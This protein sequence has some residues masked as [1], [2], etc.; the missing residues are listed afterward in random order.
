MKRPPLATGKMGTHRLGG[1]WHYPVNPWIYFLFFLGVNAFL[2]YATDSLELKFW[3]GLVGIG[4][5]LAFLLS[6]EKNLP[7]QKARDFREK[8]MVFPPLLF[9]ILLF[10]GVVFFS[11]WNLTGLSTWPMPDEG[12][13]AFYAIEWFQRGAWSIFY[14]DKGIPFLSCGCLALFFRLLPPGLFSLW[15]LP[16]LFSIATFGIG[17]WACRRFLPPSLS[18]LGAALGAFNFWMMYTGRL[19]MPTFLFLFWEVLALASLGLVWKSDSPVPRWKPAFLGVCVGIGFFIWITWIPVALLLGWAFLRKI[20]RK[21]PVDQGSILF[22]GGPVFFCLLAFLGFVVKERNSFAYLRSLWLLQGGSDGSIQWRYFISN[23]SGLFWG[24]PFSKHYGPLWG[25]MMNPVSGSLFFTGLVECR[26]RW[27]F[28]GIRWLLGGIGWFLI[29]GFLSRDFECFRGLPLLPL[30]IL[31]AAL[32]LQGLLRRV[33]VRGH[34]GWALSLLLVSASLDVF[35]LA[36]PYHRLWGTPGPGWEGLKNVEYWKA[37]EILGQL[38]REKGEGLLLADFQLDIADQTLPLADYPLDAARHPQTTLDGKNWIAVIVDLHYQPF[39]KKRFPGGQWYA[40]GSDYLQGG[41]IMLAVLPVTPAD[42]ADLDGWCAADR[43]LHSV[44]FETFQWG[45]KPGSI[46]AVLSRTYPFM[47]GDPFLESVFWHKYLYVQ[48]ALGDTAACLD[49]IQKGLQRGYPLPFLLND[50]GVLW[51][52]QGR[53]NDARRALERAVHS[54]LN[55]TLAAQNL[56]MLKRLEAKS[57]SRR[58]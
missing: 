39:L 30:L 34:S 1:P 49:A 29:P 38:E 33:P 11:L 7:P 55:L 28:S 9:W 3:G 44:T 24:T 18:F 50:E 19:C 6:R 31:V 13:M 36:G 54:E 10:A 45:S 47:K 15:L 32:G 4:L 22:W 58:P 14:T 46:L 8:N 41:G 42:R 40:L 35:H 37:H 23:L 16:A 5:P 21:M 12:T 57:S 51:M 48:K 2:S 53:Y 26:R 20:N 43:A 25:G 52:R 27:A 56:E 17:A